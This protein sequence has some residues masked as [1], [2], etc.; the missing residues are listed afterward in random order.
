[1]ATFT[2]YGYMGSTPDW[3]DL[4]ANTVVFSSSLTDLATAITVGEF[5]D[6]THAG[7]D[8]PGTDQCGTNHMNNVKYLTGSTMSVNG[9]ASEDINDT[10]LTATECTLKINFAHSP[11]VAITNARFYAFDGSVVTNE[12]VGIDAYAFERG[13]TA[14]A[15]TQI[16]DDSG[17]IGGDNTG[18]RLALGSKSS[19]TSHDWFVAIS[20][21]PEAVGAKSSFDFGV[22][23]TYS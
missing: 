13:V 5:Q 7:S 18:E 22:G 8:D 16:N 11:A 23:L 17:N 6:G 3:V 20:A 4:G 19:A 10:N 1:M 12:A 2:W 21:S 9:A 15:W 14:S